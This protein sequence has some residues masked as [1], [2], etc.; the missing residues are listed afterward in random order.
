MAMQPE[1]RYIN[2]YV[3][4]TAAC[5]PEKKPQKKSAVSLPKPKRQQKWLIQVDA[6][7]V[8]GI[9]AA[10]VLSVMLIVGLVQMNNAKEEAQMYREYAIS[11]KEENRELKDTYT[12]GYDPE[13]IRNIALAMGMVPVEEVPHIQMQLVAPET[14]VQ[15]TAWE[16]F[17]AFMVG[18]FA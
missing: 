7:A 10:M 3:S 2:A 14:E 15:P 5:Q 12:S 16:S 13:E 18:L 6:V 11:L 9:L 4:G 1:V 17:W 8:G